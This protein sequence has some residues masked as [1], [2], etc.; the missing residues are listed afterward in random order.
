VL[1]HGPG[2]HE[3]ERLPGL[4]GCSINGYCRCVRP[5]ILLCPHLLP[6]I[7]LCPHLLLVCTCCRR[8]LDLWLCSHVVTICKQHASAGWLLVCRRLLLL[9]LLLLPQLVQLLF[10]DGR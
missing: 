6:L 1:P 10:K 9:L 2:T 4:G 7:L 5:L 8:L 3:G